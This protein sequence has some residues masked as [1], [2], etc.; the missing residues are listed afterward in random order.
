M[1]LRLFSVRFELQFDIADIPAY[2]ARYSYADD[3]EVVAIGRRARE[4]G[5]YRRREFVRVCR[6]KTPRSAPLVDE[7]SAEDLRAETRIALRAGADDGERMRAL[8]RLRGVDWAT[9]SMLLHLGYPGRYPVIDIRAMH[10]LGVGR[11]S[12]SYRFWRAYIEVYGALVT[13]SAVDGRTFDRG[14]WQWSVEQGLPPPPH[15]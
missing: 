10:A 3:A 7:N 15:R 14:L 5:Y 13:Q 4:R 9:A 1:S 2:A 12:Y 11:R 8:R 6:W